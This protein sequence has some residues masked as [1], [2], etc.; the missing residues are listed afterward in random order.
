[1]LE[2][3]P[4]REFVL[5]AV[6]RPWEPNPVLRDPLPRE[7]AAFAEP[8]HVKIAWTMR[9][10]PTSEGECVFRTETRAMA[11]DIDARTKFRRYWAV[12]SP[13]VAVIR[14]AMIAAV[15][16]E[17]ERRMTLPAPAAVPA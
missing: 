5:G 1:M 16:Q 11:T 10:D 15:K 6:T 17:A 7:F 12:V 3:R 4:D 13:G 2:S 9:V 8:G 14:R